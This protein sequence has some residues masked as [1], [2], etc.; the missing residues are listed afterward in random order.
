MRFLHFPVQARTGRVFTV[1]L[2][3]TEAT[4]M[5]MDDLNF[6][7]YRTGSSFRYFGGHFNRSPALLPPVP[8]DGH[9]NI[10]V[11]LGGGAGHVEATVS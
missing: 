1:H 6:S 9:W 7:R 10:V 4:V 11:D 8:H 5:L 3:G 2:R